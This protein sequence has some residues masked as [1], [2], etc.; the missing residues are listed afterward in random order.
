MNGKGRESSLNTSRPDGWA[1]MR[2]PG[3][4]SK[5]V[6]REG[7]LEVEP[8]DHFRSPQSPP[9]QGSLPSPKSLGGGEEMQFTW[10]RQ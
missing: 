1:W 2:S 5:A 4:A 10:L 3:T 7:S 6:R 9:G 8:T